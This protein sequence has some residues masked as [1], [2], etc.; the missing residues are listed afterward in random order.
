MKKIYALSLVLFSAVSFGQSIVITKVVDGTLPH[1]GC[2]ETDGTFSPRIVEMY[3]S[4]TIDFGSNSNDY[5]LQVESNGAATEAEEY[6]GGIG[7]YMSDF[8]EVTDSF[9]Y[10]VN[11]PNN[12]GTPFY[13]G[14]LPIFEDLYPNIDAQHVIYSGYA[15]NPN[16]NDAIRVANYNGDTLIEVIDQYGNPLDVA[17]G[18]DLDATWAFQDSYAARNNG[19]AANGG[20]FDSSSFTYGGNDALDGVDCDQFTTAVPMGVFSTLA[21]EKFD[22]ISGLKMYPNPLTGSTLNITS[23]NN[24]DKTVAI[25]DVLGKQVANTVTKNGTV[26]VT[27]LTSGVYIVKITEDGKTATRKLVVK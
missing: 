24:A 15:P 26:N 8:G 4:G 12:N 19:V 1:G 11:M 17:N 16:G 22:S 23:D 25:Y 3:V 18:D 14:A 21:T 13:E 2:E 6:W 5:R 10:A 27:N 9:I 20:N 7:M